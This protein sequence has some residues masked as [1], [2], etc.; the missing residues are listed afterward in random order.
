VVAVSLAS[1]DLAG[2]RSTFMVEMTEAAAILNGATPKSLVLVDEIGRGTSTFDGLA[3]AYAIARHLAER[4]RCYSLF[5]THYFE[6]TQL[7][8]EL[9]NI[10]NVHLDAVEHKDRI[11]FLHRLEPGPADKSYGIHVAHLAGIPK[12][13]VRAAR[14][15][16]TELESHLRPEGAQPDLFSV[17]AAPGAP[18]P[19]AAIEALQALEPD[20]LTPREALDALYR[21]RSLL[22]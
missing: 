9:P 19:H 10:A 22:D 4:V 7:A 2:G 21:L 5:A 6:L 15:H 18:E 1:D 16:L 20:T 13:I 3:L 12:E 11:V 8:A 14:K 17:P